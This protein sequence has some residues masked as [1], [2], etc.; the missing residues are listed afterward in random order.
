MPFRF[1][2]E[3]ILKLRQSLEQ[4]EELLLQKANLEV[5]RVREEMEGCLRQLAE[6]AASR[7]AQVSSGAFAS[8]LHF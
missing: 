8:E 3:G 1:R 7:R 5:A 4:R 6:R 2:L